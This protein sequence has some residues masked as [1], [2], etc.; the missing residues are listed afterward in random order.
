[1]THFGEKDM[2]GENESSESSPSARGRS[3]NSAV[4]SSATMGATGRYLQGLMLS[5]KALSRKP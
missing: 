1:M 5:P 2:Y 4:Y 3:M